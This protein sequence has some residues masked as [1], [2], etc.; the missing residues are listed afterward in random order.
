MLASSP[1]TTEEYS[2]DICDNDTDD[3]SAVAVFVSVSPAYGHGVGRFIG[4][5]IVVI[6]NVNKGNNKGTLLPP[7]PPVLSDHS[8]KMGAGGGG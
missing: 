8:N 5:D 4:C 6:P 7:S 2:E 1:I 3:V